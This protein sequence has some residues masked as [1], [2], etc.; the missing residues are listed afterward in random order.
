MSKTGQAATAGNSSESNAV[1]NRTLIHTHMNIMVNASQLTT[2]QAMQVQ[3]EGICMRYSS[4]V[5]HCIFCYI[6]H[7]SSVNWI[8]GHLEN[9]GGRDTLYALLDFIP[10]PS[11][12]SCSTVLYSGPTILYVGDSSVY[13]LGSHPIRHCYWLLLSKSLTLTALGPYIIP[14]TCVRN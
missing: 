6:F 1:H 11:H 5:L 14:N 12:Y 8:P 13:Y 2:Q 4:T 7:V 10:I 3:D 9:K